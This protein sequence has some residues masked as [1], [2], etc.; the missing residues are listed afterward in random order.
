[1]VPRKYFYPWVVFEFYQTMT[2]RGEQH[3]T[4]LNF[5][6]DGRQGVLRASNIAATFG[7]LVALANSA[8]DRQWLHPSPW[9]MVRHL[10][11]DTSVGTILLC[12]Q[13]PSGMIFVDHVLQSNLFPLQHWVQS[14]GAILEAL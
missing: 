8:D 13:V 6:I 12:R 4:A 2:S 11:R 9:D 5:S 7:L 10:S 1:M 3:P 14:R